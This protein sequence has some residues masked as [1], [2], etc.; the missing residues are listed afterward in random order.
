M[1]PEVRQ[2]LFELY[3]TQRLSYE[4]I[5]RALSIH[6]ATV[7]RTIK[8][9]G[10]PRT[11]AQSLVRLSPNLVSKI[12]QKCNDGVSARQLAKEYGYKPNGM[13]ALLRRSGCKLLRPQDKV[14]RNWGFIKKTNA[15]FLYWLGWMLTDGCIRYKHYGMRDRGIDIKLSIHRN[16]RYV[17]EFFRDI[18]Q[19]TAKI[20]SSKRKKL[21]E[22]II[23]IDRDNASVLGEW[24]FVPRKSLK[25]KPTNRLDALSDR[26]FCQLYVGIIEGDGNVDIRTIK[27][28]GRQYHVMRIR[29]CSG[30]SQF[31]GWIRDR[32][33]GLGF[34]RRAVTGR[35]RKYGYAICGNDAHKL[36]RLLLKCKYHLMARKWGIKCV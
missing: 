19:P 8:K 7:Y 11:S 3:E 31:I 35:G 28:K 13:Q 32:L 29:L 21:D 30:S 6:P 25:L 9:Y 1:K 18:I 5:A 4:K 34:K 2:K 27:S 33:C 16:D 10:H 17:L 36:L 14:A 26:Q 20:Y 22:L 24:G 23:S 12:V 15:L